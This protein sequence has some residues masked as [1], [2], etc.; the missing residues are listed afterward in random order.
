V[1]TVNVSDW[2]SLEA[3][4][5]RFADL[6]DLSSSRRHIDG[7]L[8]RPS[9]AKRTAAAAPAASGSGAKACKLSP[10]GQ[11]YQSSL[12]SSL[13]P[14]S[15]WRCGGAQDASCDAESCTCRSFQ[16]SEQPIDGG[17][18]DHVQDVCEEYDLDDSD[19]M[20]LHASRRLVVQQVA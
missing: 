6:M 1:P 7:Y 10:S 12:A 19:E 15:R 5:N 2:V 14:E 3:V 16:L 13:T 8:T 9:P 11:Q 20:L 18:Y 4:A 17:L